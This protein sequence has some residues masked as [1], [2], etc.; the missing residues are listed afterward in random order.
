MESRRG[1]PTGRVVTRPAVRLHLLRRRL[2]MTGGAVLSILLLVFD[3]QAVK[4]RSVSTH[5]QIL[6][7]KFPLRE[8][9]YYIG[10]GGTA[11]LVNEHYGFLPQRYAIDIVRLNAWGAAARGINPSEPERYAIFGDTIYSSCSGKVVAAVDTVAS[12]AARTR[13]GKPGRQLCRAALSAEGR[14]KGRACSLR[15]GS[16]RV[17]RGQT[18]EEGVILGQVGNSGSTTQPHLH[19]HAERDGSRDAIL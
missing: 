18:V 16:V 7:L 14:G 9:T 6:E 8:G 13:S 3:L 12:P 19:V 2:S 1:T 5:D 10:G 17:R 4:G 15:H 11:R